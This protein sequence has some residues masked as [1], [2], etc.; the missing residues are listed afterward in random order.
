MTKTLE[1]VLTELQQGLR[2]IYGTRLKDLRLFGSQARGEAVAGSDIDVAMILEDFSYTGE[3]ISRTAPFVSHLSLQY[4][5]TISLLPLR[6]RD[7][8]TRENPF[9]M[10]LRRESLSLPK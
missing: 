6:T 10:N 9:L 5:C 7:W 1:T 4:D 3:E 8:K 2:K